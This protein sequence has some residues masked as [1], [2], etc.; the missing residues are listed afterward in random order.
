MGFLLLR[1]NDLKFE[2][3]MNSEDVI[4][5]RLFIDYGKILLAKSSPGDRQTT[6]GNMLRKPRACP[7]SQW[8]NQKSVPLCAD[9][10]DL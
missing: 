8:V 5:S 9:M 2:V 6:M 7:G 1:L 3:L 4:F 10:A